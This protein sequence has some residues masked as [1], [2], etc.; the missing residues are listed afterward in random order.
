MR[1]IPWNKLQLVFLVRYSNSAAAEFGYFVYVS[2]RNAENINCFVDCDDWSYVQGIE[3]FGTRPHAF[4][5]ASCKEARRVFKHD[6]QLVMSWQGRDIGRA[7]SRAVLKG[8]IILAMSN[9]C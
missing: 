9:G 2:P 1:P 4:R 5:R 7:G 8:V 6:Y 3:L